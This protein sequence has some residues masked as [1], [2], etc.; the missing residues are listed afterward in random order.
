[1]EKPN[2][3]EDYTR[4]IKVLESCKTMDHIKGAMKYFDLFIVKWEDSIPDGIIPNM[5]EYFRDEVNS[6]ISELYPE[7][8]EK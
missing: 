1:M 8:V 5:K 6:K 2:H 4:A 3:I 7:S